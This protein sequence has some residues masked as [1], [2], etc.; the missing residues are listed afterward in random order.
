M[1]VAE[2]NHKIVI[3]KKKITVVQDLGQNLSL[4]PDPDQINLTVNQE[5][6]EKILQAEIHVKNLVY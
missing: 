3:Q 4:D 6:P 5:I 2:V 1:E